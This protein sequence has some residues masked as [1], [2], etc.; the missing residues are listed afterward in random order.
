MRKLF[1]VPILLSALVIAAFAVSGTAQAAQTTAQIMLGSGSDT[2]YYMMNA[3]DVLYNQSPGC[4]QL[5][6]PQPLDGS[7]V[8]GN[9]ADAENFFHD[10]AAERYF[11]G[12][13]G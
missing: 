8:A 6:S 3:M 12:F 4:N 2:T 11:I 13:G 9:P 5:G 1:K 10:T 7:C